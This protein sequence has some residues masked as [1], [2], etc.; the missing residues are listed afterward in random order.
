MFR[1]FL[2]YYYDYYD[3]NVSNKRYNRLRYLK[4][5]YNRVLNEKFEYD[6]KNV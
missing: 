1:I 4:F 3:V 5:R 6:I 2:Q